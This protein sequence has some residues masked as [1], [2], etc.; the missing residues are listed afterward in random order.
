MTF[1]DYFDFPDIKFSV[2]T[3]ATL[4]PGEVYNLTPGSADAHAY[5]W[6]FKGTAL[7]LCYNYGSG[8]HRIHQ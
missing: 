2:Y 6:S 4:P 8:A 7:S 3:L 5:K 1:I